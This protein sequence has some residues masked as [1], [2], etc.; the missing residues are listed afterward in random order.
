MRKNYLN[1]D[2]TE[3]RRSAG[4]SRTR[5]SFPC[6]ICSQ[7]A[8]CE[9]F[10]E[11]K[12]EGQWDVVP[13]GLFNSVRTECRSQAGLLGNRVCSRLQLAQTQSCRQRGATGSQPRSTA[14]T[15]EHSEEPQTEVWR[16]L[17]RTWTQWSLE[18][19]SW[20][21][22][23]EHGKGGGGGMDKDEPSAGDVQCRQIWFLC[24]SFSSE[25]GSWQ[26]IRVA[27]SSCTVDTEDRST[28]ATLPLSSHA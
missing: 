5:T 1:I 10:S 12:A 21:C 27:A 15:A 23:G 7:M 9:F 3:D 17:L 25:N 16:G 28:R 14:I 8:P 13:V 4:Y 19:P 22:V 6:F 2:V 24:R 18:W 26:F 11:R 20:K